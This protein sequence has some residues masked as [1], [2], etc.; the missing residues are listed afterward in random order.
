[1]WRYRLLETVVSANGIKR[2]YAKKMN[3]SSPE[4]SPVVRTIFEEA[5]KGDKLCT[6]TLEYTFQVLGKKLS[7]LIH[8][9]TPEAIVFVGIFQ[10][11]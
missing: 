1:M 5:R 7:D 2:T 4:E 9:L 6:E 10:N 8:I 3:F 11:L